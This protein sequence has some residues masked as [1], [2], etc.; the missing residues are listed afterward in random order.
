MSLRNVYT[1][2]TFKKHVNY[3]Q[4][5]DVWRWYVTNGINVLFGSIMNGLSVPFEPFEACKRATYV[6]EHK[7]TPL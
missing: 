4:W 1:F 3:R 6:K 2:Q 5:D 7:K